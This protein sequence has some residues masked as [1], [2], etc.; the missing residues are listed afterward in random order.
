MTF[1]G[2]IVF[3]RYF[4][5][6]L[7]FFQFLSGLIFAGYD[8]EPQV[9]INGSALIYEGILNVDGFT[10]IKNATKKTEQDIKWFHINSAGGDIDASMDIGLWVFSRGLNVRVHNV[11]LSSCANYIFPAGKTK[12]IEKNAIVA[13]HGSA[14]QDSLSTPPLDQI[15]DLLSSI[16]DPKEKEAQRNKIIKSHA[17]YIVEMKQKQKAFFIKIGVDEGI[18]IVGQT[19]MYKVINFWSMSV[20]DMA[21]FGIIDVKAPDSYIKTVLSKSDQIVLLNITEGTNRQRGHILN[22]E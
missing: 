8:D 1:E 20:A 14:L 18:T 10:K 2:S 15:E 16:E 19:K 12:E 9:R 3:A 22:C 11:C 6:T 17:N 5:F 4:I 7:F 21:K 13:W